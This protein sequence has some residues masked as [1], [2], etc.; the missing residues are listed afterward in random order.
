MQ[1]N[2]APWYLFNSTTKEI[3]NIDIALGHSSLDAIDKKLD[4]KEAQF[5]CFDGFCI[6]GF[7]NARHQNYNKT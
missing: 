3:S 4:K 5:N 7:D 6:R 2:M 1:Q